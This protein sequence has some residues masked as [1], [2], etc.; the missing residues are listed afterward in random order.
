MMRKGVIVG[1]LF[2]LLQ[3]VEATAYAQTSDHIKINTIGTEIRSLTNNDD[4]QESSPV[5]FVS[6]QTFSKTMPSSSAL[7]VGMPLRSGNQALSVQWRKSFATPEKVR[8]FFRLGFENNHFMYMRFGLSQLDHFKLA[9]KKTS[10]PL[11]YRSLD[12]RYGPSLGV[13]FGLNHR[14]SV[15]AEYQPEFSIKDKNQYSR[16]NNR[17]TNAWRRIDRLDTFRIRF[18]LKLYSNQ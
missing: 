4:H 7:I 3:T 11:V 14:M 5:S 9:K 17:L 18:N 10:S 12:E 6:S 15:E 16:A 13:S 8:H 1:L 2:T